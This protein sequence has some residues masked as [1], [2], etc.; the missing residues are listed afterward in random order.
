MVTEGRTE[1]R[2]SQ[3]VLR[4]RHLSGALRKE[5]TFVV[6][7]ILYFHCPKYEHCTYLF[8]NVLFVQERHRTRQRHRQREK[9]APREPDVGT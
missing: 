4:A 2:A 6:E 8:K 1:A 5:G 7:G 3:G 9:Q